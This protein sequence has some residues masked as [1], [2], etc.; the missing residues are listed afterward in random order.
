M[1]ISHVDKDVATKV[2]NGMECR[3]GKLTVNHG[4]KHTLSGIDISIN[5]DKTV[6]IDT[7]SYIKKIL[8]AFSGKIKIGATSLAN[9]NVFNIKEG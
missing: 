3:F 4:K 8:E 6:S 9:R 7:R 5:D 2:R 1:K